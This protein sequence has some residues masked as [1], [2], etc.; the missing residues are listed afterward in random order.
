MS[1]LTDSTLTISDPKSGL[2]V[3]LDHVQV[4]DCRV[5]YS[6]KKT[7]SYR[8]LEYLSG[9]YALPNHYANYTEH[10]L[11]NI[12]STFS[13]FPSPDVDDSHTIHKSISFSAC[14]GG[15]ITTPLYKNGGPLFT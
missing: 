14:D 6:L 10:Y 3:P 9:D 5:S 11:F 1:N 15:V 7:P 8:T 4:V 2:R 12:M 13:P